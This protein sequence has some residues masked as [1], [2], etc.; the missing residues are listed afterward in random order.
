MNRFLIIFFY[1]LNYGIFSQTN[2]VEVLLSS[3]NRIYEQ[4]LYG[5]QSSFD[6]EL[7]VSYLD[8]INSEQTD[9]A[10]Y[11]KQIENSKVPLFITVGPAATKIAKEYLKNTPIVFSMVNAPKT[12]GLDSQNLCGVSMDISIGEF[13][14]A[15]KDIKPNA[16]SVYAFYTTNDGEY[17]SAEGEYSDLKY[18]L[19]YNRKKL[20]DKKDLKKELEEIKNKADAFLMINDP[21]YASSADFQILSEFIKKNKMI[22]MTGFPALVKVG[23]TFGISP[24]YSKIGVLTGQMAS[25]IYNKNSSCAD[26]RIILPD[27]SSFFLNENYA[28]ESGIDLPNTIIERAKLTKLF[29]AGVNLINENKLNSAKIVFETILKRDPGNKA[30]YTFQQLILEKLSGSK[31]K[32][33][34]ISA[35]TH[36]KNKRFSQAR[37]DY[38][39]VL[40]INPSIQSAKDGLLACQQGQSEQ[41]RQ[42][43]NQLA[44]SG[45]SFEAIRMFL[46]SLRTLPSNSQAQADLNTIRSFEAG[47]MKPYME[48]G[49]LS[50]NERDYTKSIEIFENVLLVIPN[51]KEAL[52]YLRLSYIKKDAM[53]AL[54]KKQDG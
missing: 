17:S 43:G 21:L 45:K 2:K 11:F 6:T 34:L 24:D 51:H 18:K 10:N 42:Q 49:I 46:A 32:E 15:L 27:Q 31:T 30:A 16:K 14:Q 54:K 41:E 50:F 28:K 19:I 8:I 29:D 53:I 22:L 26:E 5:I 13:F 39:K 12:L 7:K 25:R 1:I 44:R 33:L 48:K 9:I 20:S 38:Q 35:D 37:T 40:S 23:A 4:A 36:F 52:E 3:D 47:N